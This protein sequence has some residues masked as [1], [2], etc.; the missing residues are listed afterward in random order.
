MIKLFSGTP[1]SGKSLHTAEKIYYALRAGRPVIANFD[2]N[3]QF[4]Q[5]RRSRRVE[6]HYIP[7][8][9]LNG[10]L[11]VIPFFVQQNTSNDPASLFDTSST[12]IMP[13]EKF[14]VA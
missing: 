3:L 2:I 6:F 1:G 8:D 4:V 7:N 12:D 9:E 5:G 14:M 13:A 11:S 10:A